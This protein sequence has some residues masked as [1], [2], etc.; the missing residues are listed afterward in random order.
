MQTHHKIKIIK[1]AERDLRYEQTQSAVELIDDQGQAGSVR[2]AVTTIKGWIGEL[3]QK[4]DA[5]VLATRV[6]LSSLSRA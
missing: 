4:K 5:E 3:R 1:R 6:L 2:D